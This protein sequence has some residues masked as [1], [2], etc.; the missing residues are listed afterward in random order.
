M[1]AALPTKTKRRPGLD[2][3]RRR[4]TSIAAGKFFNLLNVPTKSIN[5]VGHG[6]APDV[7]GAG[8]APP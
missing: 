1:L 7:A 4:A 8:Q 6:L 5:G 3:N 2:L